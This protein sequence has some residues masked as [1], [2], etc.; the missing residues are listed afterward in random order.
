MADVLSQSQI[1]ALLKSMQDGPPK[2]EKEEPK[3]VEVSVQESPKKEEAPAKEDN[4]S[5]Y[6]FYSPRKFTK[7][8]IR[9]LKSIF[10][11]YARI[12]TSQVNGIFRTMTDITVLELRETRY[13][14]YVNAFHENDCMTIV[15]T[16]VQDK[17][18][19]NVPMM[20][21]ISPGLTLTLVSHMLGGSDTVI[22]TED[23]YRYTDVEMALYKRIMEYI[24]HALGDGFSNYINAEFKI[25][26]IETN[27]SMVQ[28]VGLDETVVLAVMNVDISGLAMERIRICLPGTLLEHMFKIIDNR[29]HLARGF[30]YENNQDTIMEHLK[31]SSFPMTG[32][33][34]V[35]KLDIEDLYHLKVGDV[36]DL[37]KAKNSA[38]K[39]YVG[40]QPWFTGKMGVYKKNIAIRIEDRIIQKE[41]KAMEA[42]S[43]AVAK[44]G[45]TEEIPE[46]EISPM[47]VMAQDI[48]DLLDPEPSLDD[49]E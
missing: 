11:N 36:I 43:D 26:K 1:D 48:Q 5:K 33:L 46:E 37:N 32:Q 44:E 22:K 10:D 7:E 38:V 15:D 14:E 9:L 3:V 2:E 49:E 4:F 20:S 29:K 42:L 27:P 16:Y 35:V 45:E 25:A 24:V 17:G 28:E 21:Y 19:S 8:K 23:D 6:D 41:D 39:L 47:N 30:A 31:A 12:L 18:K 34:G 40:R 13:Y